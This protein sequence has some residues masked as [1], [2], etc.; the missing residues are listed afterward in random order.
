MYK[1]VKSYDQHKSLGLKRTLR[2]LS[3]DI[4]A[5]VQITLIG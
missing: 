3:K 2:Y 5:K 4:T 1:A